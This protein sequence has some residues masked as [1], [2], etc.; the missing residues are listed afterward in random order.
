MSS[1]GAAGSSSAAFYPCPDLYEQPEAGPSKP[2]QLR[3]SLATSTDLLAR[4]DLTD[5]YDAHVRPYL[6]VS[7]EQPASSAANTGGSGSGVVVQKV[8]A[9]EDAAVRR[10]SPNKQKGKGKEQ[11]LPPASAAESAIGLANAKGVR[12]DAASGNLSGDG[13]AAAVEGDVVPTGKL[14][15]MEKGFGKYVQDMP[16]GT[17]PCFTIV[18]PAESTLQTPSLSSRTTS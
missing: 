16:S 6:Q 10:Q 2:R 3:A 9:Y 8:F 1:S 11:L 18:A 15:K 5:A 17:F 14:K 7:A 12:I 4:F 13:N